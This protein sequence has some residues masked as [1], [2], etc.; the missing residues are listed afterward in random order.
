[1]SNFWLDRPTLVTGA[2]GLVGGWLVRRLLEAGADVV[3]LVRDWVPQSELA[4]SGLLERVKVVRGDVRGQATLE[5]ALG[6]YEVHT[7]IHLAAQTIVGIANR[8]PVSTFEANVAGTWALL[9]ACRRSPLV[10]QVVVASSDKAYGEHEV[11]PYSEEAPLTGRHPYDVSKSC[12]DL[13]AQSYAHTYGLPG[14]VTRCGNFYGGGDLNW[15]RIIPGTIRSVLRG[16]RPVIR[17]DGRYVRDYFY[18]EDGAAANMILAEHLARDPGLRGEAFNFSNEIQVTVLELV[19]RLL[20]LMGSDLEPDVRNE[21]TNE[22]RHQYLSAA[23]ARRV[24]GWEPLFTLDEG[25][26]RTVDWY[27]NFLGT[28]A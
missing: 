12:A 18:V 3:C 8:N 24:L 26:R 22:I 6:E 15:N 27:R 11:L 4:R 25:L 17:S 14:A 13:I 9:E 21:A 2:T 23:K 19:E 16:Q 5:R 28:A 1:V 10:G 7:V 20:K